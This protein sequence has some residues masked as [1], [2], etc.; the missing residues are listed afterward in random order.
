MSDTPVDAILVRVDDGP[1]V[2]ILRDRYLV[3]SRQ[4]AVFLPQ[5]NIL[6]VDGHRVTTF[7]AAGY[8]AIVLPLRAGTHTITVTIVGGP[9][10][11][12]SRAIVKVGR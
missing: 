10:D 4:R 11:G 6:G 5:P 7:V 3:V 1:P 2:D 8:S 9:F 12:T